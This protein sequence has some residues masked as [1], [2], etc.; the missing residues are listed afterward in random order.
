MKRGLGRYILDGHQPVSCED[1]MT[2]GR[3]MA[4]A[5]RCVARTIQGDVWVSTVFL[6]LDHNFHFGGPPQLFETM[7]FHGDEGEDM[8]RYSTWEEAEAG[9]AEM[10]R[11]V[12]SKRYQKV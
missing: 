12:F 1:L 7:A 11:K 3:W 9:H 6:G 5:D 10:V 8:D 2:W 4:D